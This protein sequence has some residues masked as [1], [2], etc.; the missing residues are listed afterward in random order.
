MEWRCSLTRPGFPGGKMGPVAF[1]PH[2]ENSIGQA[3]K[4]TRMYA[5]LLWGN[6]SQ[7]DQ[8]RW[9]GDM[10]DLRCSKIRWWSLD[11]RFF[12]RPFLASQISSCWPRPRW[13]GQGEDLGTSGVSPTHWHPWRASLYRQPKR[14]AFRAPDSLESGRSDV[15]CSWQELSSAQKLLLA[16]DYIIYIYILIYTYIWYGGLS[17]AYAIEIPYKIGTPNVLVHY[18][19]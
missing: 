11:L 5:M 6:L 19:L 2:M 18:G 10:W 15:K 17:G 14:R 12:W 9:I 3:R 16:H 4:W 13:S 1:N 8:I 7:M